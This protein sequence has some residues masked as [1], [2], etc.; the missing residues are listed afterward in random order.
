MSGRARTVPMFRPGMA[1]IHWD[2]VHCLGE[3]PDLLQCP[4][5]TWNGAECSLVA[6]VTCTQQQ[7]RSMEKRCSVQT[8]CHRI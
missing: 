2:A 5:T 1:K 8:E 6:A 7:G 3:E 4:K